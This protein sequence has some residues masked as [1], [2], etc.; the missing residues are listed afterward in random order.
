M[1]RHWILETH[2]LTDEETTKEKNMHITLEVRKFLVK[3]SV[4]LVH[5]TN[6]CFLLLSLE[7]LAKS[8]PTIAA[9]RWETALKAAYAEPLELQLWFTHRVAGSEIATTHHFTE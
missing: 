7:L 5:R 3:I 2:S 6:P 9:K 8:P 4:F 1:T